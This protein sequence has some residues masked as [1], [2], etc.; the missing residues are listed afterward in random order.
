VTRE[1]LREFFRAKLFH[2]PFAFGT[3]DSVLG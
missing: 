2:Y 1:S 3:A